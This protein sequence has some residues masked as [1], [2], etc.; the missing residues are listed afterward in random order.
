[1]LT[2]FANP[3]ESLKSGNYGQPPRYG[4]WAKQAIIYFVGLLLMK[5][6]V[7][8]IFQLL[9]WVAWVGDWALRWTEGSEALQITFVMFIFPVCMNAIQYYI[10]DSFIKD[11]GAGTHMPVAGSDHSSEYSR[12]ASDE[13]F[14]DRTEQG[15]VNEEN[16]K[17]D[18]LKK[19]NGE[20]GVST[21]EFKTQIAGAE[22]PGATGQQ[23]SGSSSRGDA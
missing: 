21:K 12:V 7:Y 9:P 1:M 20:T 5:L 6:C 17:D 16:D 23:S 10:V 14:D 13:D 11:P 8:F 4:W 19:G 22:E 15:S 18:A 2:P 3:P